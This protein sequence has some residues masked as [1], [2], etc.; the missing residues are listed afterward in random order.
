MNEAADKPYPDNERL[1]SESEADY[2]EEQI[3]AL[4]GVEGIRKRPSMYISGTGAPG[5][6]HLVFEVIDNSIDEAVNGYATTISAKINDFDD[7]IAAVEKKA[8]L[9]FRK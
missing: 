6:H 5:L 8:G 7:K 4:P 2:G 9:E 1:S 3:S